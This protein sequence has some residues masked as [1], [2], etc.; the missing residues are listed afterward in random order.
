MEI[1]FNDNT[2]KALVKKLNEE[3][4]SAVR[5]VITGIS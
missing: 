2:R 1:L 4:K 3:N 5:F